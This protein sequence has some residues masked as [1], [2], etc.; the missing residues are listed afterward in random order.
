[1]KSLRSSHSLKNYSFIHIACVCGCV[2]IV[3][4]VCAVCCVCVCEKISYIICHRELWHNKMIK[5]YFTL[6][7]IKQ[8]ISV[9]PHEY[10]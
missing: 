3:W 5:K 10:K 4:F 9:S 8:Q 7:P 1:M 6:T 2:Y